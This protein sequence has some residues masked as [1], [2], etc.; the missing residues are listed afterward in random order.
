[1][2][3]MKI[4]SVLIVTGLLAA[5]YFTLTTST[6][7]EL[8][9]HFNSFVTQYSKNYQ[10]VEERT[11]RMTIFKEQLD[12]INNHNAQGKSW[13]LGVNE[14]SDW[15]HEEYKKMLGFR[16][17]KNHAAEF[18]TLGDLATNCKDL[19]L[20]DID[21]RDENRVT[22]VKNQGGCGSCWAFSAVANLEAAYAK[23]FG[24]L[25]TFSEQQ[26]VACNK[27]SH[28]CSGGLMYNGFT[29]WMHHAPLTEAEY[30]YDIPHA[31]ECQEG[32]V[33]ATHEELEWGYRVDITR[34]CL[35]E[36]LTHNVVSVAI[37]AENDDFRS[38]K[39]GVITGDG[40]GIDLDH[41][42]TVV[43][44]ISK[45]NAWVIK[46]S[47]GPDW[48]EGG[49]VRIDNS[50]SVGTCGI[51]QENSQATYDDSEYRTAY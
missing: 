17:T 39:S 23:Q 32:S 40:C 50:K 6:V 51:N 44:Y 33:E 43:G 28:G 1:V 42:V 15:T 16:S 9:L 11:F 29:H 19:E 10:N 3:S 8:D 26:L 24:E 41:G 22:P 13:T 25:V 5:T 47:W 14:F 20:K 30:P 2:V 7:D 46:N 36:A 35:Y 38:Y 49:F 34:E 37:R 18:E 48:G 21:W 27:F 12:I 45:D 31:T 4:L